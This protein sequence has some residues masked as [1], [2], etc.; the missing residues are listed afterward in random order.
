[1]PQDGKVTIKIYDI[2]GQEVTTLLDEYRKADRYEI[3]FNSAGLAS[4]VYFYRIQVND[5]I[6]TKK[7][8]L[9]K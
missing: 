5:F 2:L 8:L 9:L 4:G 7:M 3:A 1:M 6:Q